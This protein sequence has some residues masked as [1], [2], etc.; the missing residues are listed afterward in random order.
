MMKHFIQRL[1]VFWFATLAIATGLSAACLWQLRQSAFYKPAFLVNAVPEDRF[2]YIVLGASTGLTT[3]DTKTIDSI[4]PT[5]GLNLAVDDTSMPGHYLMLQHFLAQGKKTTYCILAPNN[6]NF[7]TEHDALSN[8]DYR[9]LMY[10]NRPYVQDYYRQFSGRTARLLQGS[11]WFPVLGVAY[12]N[13]ELFYPALL[14]LTDSQRRH[15]FDDRGNYAYPQAVHTL[16][17]GQTRAVKSLRFTNPYLE[18]I[19][20]LCAQHKITLLCYVS[21]MASTTIAADTENYQVINHSDLLTDTSL[22]YD[23]VHVNR[24]GRNRVGKAFATQWASL[25]TLNPDSTP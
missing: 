18:K 15:R 10:V 17:T 4:L 2:D 11:A 19:K 3:L 21:P 12:Y 16:P 25:L 13:A 8:N 7:G 22:F 20:A 23:E 6:L 5:R 14:S 9:F 24:A 1:A